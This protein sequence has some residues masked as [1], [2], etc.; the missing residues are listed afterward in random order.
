MDFLISILYQNI[1][2]KVHLK[3]QHEFGN[4]NSQCIFY[5]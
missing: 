2:I 1:E 3:F 5:I 4:I